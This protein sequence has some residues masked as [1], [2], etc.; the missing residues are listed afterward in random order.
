MRGARAKACSSHTAQTESSVF[1]GFDDIVID[2]VDA[3]GFRCFAGSKGQ[4]ES[5][6]RDIRFI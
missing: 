3:K 5:F 4:R 2:D 1:G 6:L